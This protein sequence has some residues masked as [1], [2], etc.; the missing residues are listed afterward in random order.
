MGK[1]V[2]SFDFDPVESKRHY[3]EAEKTR[4]EVR[5]LSDLIVKDLSAMAWAAAN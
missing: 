5:R 4:A 2:K 1:F 3:A